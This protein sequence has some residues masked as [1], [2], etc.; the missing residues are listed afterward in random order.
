MMPEIRHCLVRGYEP[1]VQAIN[2]P[3]TTPD[4]CSPLV[5]KSNAQIIVTWNFNDFP[6]DRVARWIIA[7]ESP[8]DYLLDQIGLDREAVRAAVNDIAA[9]C[10]AK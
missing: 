7:A 5:Q 2:L 4:T 8:K 3:D 9:A 10:T 6:Q 1:L